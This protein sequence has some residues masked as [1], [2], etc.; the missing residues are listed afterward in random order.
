VY[1]RLQAHT[2]YAPPKVNHRKHRSEVLDVLEKFG[3]SE[4]WQTPSQLDRDRAWLTLCGGDE[5]A[6]SQ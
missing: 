2:N 5:R 6:C 1:Q 3:W 4:R